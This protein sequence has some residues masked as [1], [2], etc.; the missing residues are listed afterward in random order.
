M[1]IES[2]YLKNFRNVEEQTYRFNPHFTV[3]IGINGRGKSTWL[4]ALR[5]ACG[6][7]LL[8]IPDTIKRHIV[9]NEIRQ[10]NNG[11]F[12]LSHTPVIVEAVGFFPEYG[13]T[14]VKWRRRIPEGK[15]ATT[16]STEDVGVV[17]DLGKAKYDK[18]QSRRDDLDLPVIAFFGT[19]R[20]YGS[21]R[22]RESRIGRKIFKE[23]YHSWYEMRSSIFGYNSWLSSYHTL[24]RHEKEYVETEGAFWEAIHK[25]NPYITE[26]EFVQ[27]E[28]WLKVVMDN[29]T[30]ELLPLHLHSDGIISFTEMVA[31]L[32]YRC[33]VLNGSKREQAIVDTQ[34]VVMID[35]LDLHLHPNWQRHVV[36]DLKRA[37]PNIQFVATTHTN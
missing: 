17:R 33:I 35:E 23:G 24:V 21:A 27:N 30:S 18:M 13:G 6:A 28:I 25:S 12:L 16:S 29:Y 26:V 11:S 2:L 19:S 22:N 9:S 31:E 34:G 14:A 36:S 32:A 8:T 5:V 3:L 15:N 37:F 7:Y 10:S 20:V 1:R 4:H